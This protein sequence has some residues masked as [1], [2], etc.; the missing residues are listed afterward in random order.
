MERLTLCA[1]ILCLAFFIM[2]CG[3]G[4]GVDEVTC[5]GTL[6]HDERLFELANELDAEAAALKAAEGTSES[7]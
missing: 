7:E 4:I 6:W 1:A 5:E 3:C 2:C